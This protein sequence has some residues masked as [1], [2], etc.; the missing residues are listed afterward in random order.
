MLTQMRL[1]GLVTVVVLITWGAALA[2]QLTVSQGG[3]PMPM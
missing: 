2:W 3:S 1:Q